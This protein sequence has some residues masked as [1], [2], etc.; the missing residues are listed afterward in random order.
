MTLIE[1]L[2]LK[3]TFAVLNLSNT[4]NIGNIA[5]YKSACLLVNWKVHAVCDLIIIVKG[6]GLLNITGSRVLRKSDNISETVLDREFVTTG[7]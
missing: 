1:A 2:R 3:V 5:C 7:H 4:H 6:E